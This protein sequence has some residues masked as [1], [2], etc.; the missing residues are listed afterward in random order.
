MKIS[1]G[2][3]RSTNNPDMTALSRIA[4]NAR[5]FRRVPSHPANT[6]NFAP[7]PRMPEPLHVTGA[8]D[9][10]YDHVSIAILS[11]S[12]VGCLLFLDIISEGRGAGRDRV[13]YYTLK[14]SQ[15]AR[16]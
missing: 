6:P 12:R 15:K 11:K 14:C 3:L 1:T 10:V 13:N 7:G 2:M 16:P 9:W 4:P 8:A 5:A